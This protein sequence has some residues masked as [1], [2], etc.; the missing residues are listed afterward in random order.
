[1]NLTDIQQA[2]SRE[3]LGGWLFYDFRQ[4]N[5]IAYQILGLDQQAFYSRRWFYFVPTQ[6]AP[7]A[8]VSAVE[9]HVLHDLPGQRLFFSTWQEMRD[10]LGTLLFPGMRVAMSPSP[11][12]PTPY[13]RLVSSGTVIPIPS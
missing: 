3:G 2:L 4:S 6:G 13:I 7:T 10:H 12:N 1:M 8:L 5:P 11:M 9:A